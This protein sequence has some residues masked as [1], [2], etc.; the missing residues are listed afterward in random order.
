MP[1]ITVT[2]KASTR[3]GMPI[4]GK[5]PRIGAA[6]TPASPASAT[7]APNTMSHTRATSTPSTCTIS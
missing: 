2:T 3:I 6:R 7:P 4:S 5:T 1:P